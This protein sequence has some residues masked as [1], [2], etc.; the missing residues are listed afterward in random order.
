MLKQVLN[1]TEQ[2]P[3]GTIERMLVPKVNQDS[4]KVIKGFPT[5]TK[6]FNWLFEMFD[7]HGPHGEIISNW[8]TNKMPDLIDSKLKQISDT[9]F[10]EVETGMKS[11]EECILQRNL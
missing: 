5:D 6:T 4:F 8:S 10:Q 7:G 9:Y 11:K 1:Q 3:Q 2:S